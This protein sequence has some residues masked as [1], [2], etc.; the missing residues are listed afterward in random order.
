MKNGRNF[1]NLN[2]CESSVDF[3]H[4]KQLL[5]RQSKSW[6]P[7]QVFV[8]RAYFFPVEQLPETHNHLNILIFV[9]IV[10]KRLKTVAKI[11]ANDVMKYIN[12]HTK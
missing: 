6:I 2:Q 12:R 3:I 1:V 10:L 7:G 5:I 11:K 4:P 9:W 8:V